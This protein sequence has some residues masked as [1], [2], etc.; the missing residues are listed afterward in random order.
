MDCAEEVSLLRGRLGK[1]EGVRDLSFDIFRARMDVDYDPR[2]VKAKEIEAAVSTLG[3]KALPWRD[4]AREEGSLW[5]R[6]GRHILAWISGLALA[7]GM[8]WQAVHSGDLVQSLLV[9]E[10]GHHHL[11]WGAVFLFQVAMAAGVI[12]ALPKAWAALRALRPDM[13]LL[14]VLSMMGAT[15]LGEWT[16]AATLSF[17]FALAAMLESW[18]MARAREAISKLLQVTPPFAV[19]LHHGSHHG[20]EDGGQHEHPM[21]VEDVPVGATVRVKPG[22]RIPCDGEVARGEALVN[23]ALITG[24]SAAIEKREGDPVFAGTINE[25]GMIEVRTTRAASDTTLARMIRMVE[26]SQTR[27]APS[28]QFVEKFTRYY[29]PA[30]FLLAFSVALL[31][32]L[33]GAGAW[34]AWFYQGMVILLISCPC[35]LVIS[36]PVSVVAALTSAARHGVLVKG[37]T[38]L[39]EAAKVRAVAFDKT[40]VLTTGRPQVQEMIPLDGRGKTEVLEHLARLE[41]ASEHPLA[42]AILRYA[43][44]NGVAEVAS[45]S[46]RAI[47]GRGAEAEVEGKT[48]WAGSTRMLRE[49]GLEDERAAA[50]ALRLSDAEHTVVA[51]GTDEAAWAL[52]GVSDPPR[53]EAKRVMNELRRQGIDDLVMLTGDNNATAQRVARAIGMDEV[54]AEL[55]PEDKAAAIVELLRKH[56]HVAMVGDGVND[57]QALAYSSVGITLGRQ[58]TDVAKETADVV[59]MAN[60]LTRLPFLI[61]HARRTVSVIKQ[62]IGFALLTKL[63]FL[64]AALMGAATLWMAVAADMG[65]TFIVTFNGLRL[66]RAR[67]WQP[68]RSE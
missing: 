8:T 64:V 67:S 47:Q 25:N 59:F 60:D 20:A 6:H 31:P 1:M 16:E 29:T 61:S 19:V 13:N 48:F 36:T 21:P 34:S 45:A 7:G 55:L 49:K 57:A 37:G 65:A 12:H 62:N 54:Q 38:F 15:A 5:D 52:L 4:E 63:A 44:L 23:Q 11:P 22:E 42:Q 66:L 28:E 68:D 39:E 46:F 24:E 51:C 50:E 56:R 26:E 14:V 33:V 53:P 2:A 9:H 27:R 35:A 10:H 40:G 41:Q 58:G 3:M 32:P 18:S 43:A 30:V 17:L